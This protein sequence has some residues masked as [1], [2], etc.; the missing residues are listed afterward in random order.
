MTGVCGIS[1]VFPTKYT[2]IALIGHHYNS[3]P[4]KR[5]KTSRLYRTTLA[6]S[7]LYTL[8]IA[9][10]AFSPQ[11]ITTYFCRVSSSMLTEV[12]PYSSPTTSSRFRSNILY[13]LTFLLISVTPTSGLICC[14]CSHYVSSDCFTLLY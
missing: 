10:Q 6:S 14:Y 9:S 11:V 2:C 4:I 7:T 12:I 5:L 13:F 3:R 1:G 8:G